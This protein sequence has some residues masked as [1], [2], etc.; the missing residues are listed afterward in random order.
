M[1]H[2][3]I[4]KPSRVLKVPGSWSRLITSDQAIRGEVSGHNSGDQGSVPF[5]LADEMVQK[6]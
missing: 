2:N 1:L 6:R 5:V 3:L 4:R